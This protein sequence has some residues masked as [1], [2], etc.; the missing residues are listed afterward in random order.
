MDTSTSEEE[1]SSKTVSGDQGGVQP[2]KPQDSSGTG[3]D[4]SQSVTGGTSGKDVSA[5]SASTQDDPQ[6][7]DKDPKPAIGSRVIK[8]AKP[9]HQYKN[10]SDRYLLLHFVVSP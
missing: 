4:A 2:T 6:S 7:T 1:N 3:A 10:F 8:K 9:R 5:S